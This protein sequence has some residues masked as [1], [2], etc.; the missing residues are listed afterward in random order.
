VTSRL[1]VL[2]TVVVAATVSGCA[3]R[4]GATAAESTVHDFHAAVA[5]RDGAAACR[6]LAPHTREAVAVDADEPCADAILAGDAGVTLADSDSGS[7]SDVVHVAG[8]QAQV[9]GPTDVVFLAVSGDG[10]VITAAG[11]TPRPDRPYDCAIEGD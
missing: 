3:S 8:R 2:L 5:A 11:C 9:V 1:A 7:G 6:L 10:W 4:P